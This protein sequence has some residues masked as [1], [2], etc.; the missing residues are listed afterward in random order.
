M[1]MACLSNRTWQFAHRQSRFA[2]TSGPSC[3][4]PSG[5]MWAASAYPPVTLKFHV[6]DLAREVMELFDAAAECGVAH[7]PL[8]GGRIR[9]A[10]R[11]RRRVLVLLKFWQAFELELLDPEPVLAGRFQRSVTEYR[12]E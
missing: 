6:A 9:S 1:R 5:W 4:D 10:G 11:S 12:P 2:S 8:G 7:D 3:G